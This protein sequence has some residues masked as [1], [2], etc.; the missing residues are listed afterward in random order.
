MSVFCSLPLVSPVPFSTPP[1]YSVQASIRRLTVAA[2]LGYDQISTTPTGAAARRQA[3]QATLILHH[4]E[5]PLPNP[6]RLWHGADATRLR[7]LRRP[8]AEAAVALWHGAA[9]RLLL[10]GPAAPLAAALAERRPGWVWAGC[11]L[12]DLIKALGFRIVCPPDREPAAVARDV[13]AYRADLI[14][15]PSDLLAIAQARALR[16]GT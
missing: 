14:N 2:L 6:A 13:A 11:E 10:L 8:G 15:H 16:Q 3:D 7:A 12:S 4:A 1:T 5:W 9:L